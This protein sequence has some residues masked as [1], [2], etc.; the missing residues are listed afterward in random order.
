MTT[1][2]QEIGPTVNLLKKDVPS[3]QPIKLKAWIMRIT[4]SRKTLVEK[5]VSKMCLMNLAG[6][7]WKSWI[8]KMWRWDQIGHVFHIEQIKSETDTKQLLNSYINS[9]QWMKLSSRKIWFYSL[10]KYPDEILI[11]HLLS[12]IGTLTSDYSPLLEEMATKIKSKICEL[13]YYN[14]QLQY[15]IWLNYIIW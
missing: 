13:L 5:S 15:Y 1:T 14:F 11:W 9:A 2:I 3:I 6:S 4:D 7:K 10:K 12:S 8:V